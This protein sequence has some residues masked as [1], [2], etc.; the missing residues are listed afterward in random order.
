MKKI[1]N[2][3]GREYDFDITEAGC[4][5][6]MAKAL[7]QLKEDAE[8]WERRWFGQDGTPVSP[9]GALLDG[10]MIAEH[11]AEIRRFFDTLF[12]TGSG[13][14]ILGESNSAQA[15]D[16]AYMDFL[17]FAQMQV[18]LFTRVREEVEARY[19]ER[20]ERMVHPGKTESAETS[21]QPEASDHGNPD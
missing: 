11:C 4:V 8:C 15:C 21:K 16:E 12:G 14:A 17:C 3:G 9:N 2:Y 1:W 6:R 20:L 19:R 13:T 18:D 7:L 5:T 10:T